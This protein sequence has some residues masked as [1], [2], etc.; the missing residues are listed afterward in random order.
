MKQAIGVDIGGTKIAAA[1]IDGK[2]TIQHRVDVASDTRSAEHLFQTVV[3]AIQEVLRLADLTVEELSGIGVGLPGKVDALNGIAVFQNNLPWPNFPIVERLSQEFKQTAIAIDNDVKVAAYAEYRLAQ[4]A[5][6]DVFG[7]LTISTGIACTN[8]VNNQIIR[9]DGFSGEIGFLPVPSSTGLRSLETVCAGPGIQR[10]ARL[11]YDDETITTA[12]VFERA[13]QGDQIADQI[14][15]Q[16]AAGVAIGLFA[17]ICLL[18]PKEIV[19]GGSVALKNPFYIERVKHVL[20]SYA[21]AE[22]LHILPHIRLSELEGHNGLIGAG[23]LV[24][25]IEN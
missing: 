1:L 23:F 20:E 3:G 18:D 10:E 14:V 9:G 22:Q 8:I 13:V 11:L 4:L 19:V 21:H 25:P 7:Y 24:L 17:M 16:S 2:G 5:P 15:N 12:Q 6:L